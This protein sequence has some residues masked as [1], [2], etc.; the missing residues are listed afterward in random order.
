MI[1]TIHFLYNICGNQIHLFIRE[2]SRFS[3]THYSRK[4]MKSSISKQLLKNS[5]NSLFIVGVVFGLPLE[6]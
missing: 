1:K 2:D 4:N 3:K 5:K 6:D